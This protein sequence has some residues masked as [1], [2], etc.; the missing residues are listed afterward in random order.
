MKR[1]GNARKAA[2][3]AAV[4]LLAA[5]LALA[6]S[7]CG[8]DVSRRAAGT[9]GGA[10]SQA[11]PAGS[12]PY[13]AAGIED[14]EAFRRMFE[15][16]QDAVARGDQEKAAEYALYP[17]RVNVGK[18]AVA[19]KDREAFVKQYDRIFTD[20]VRKALAEQDA[21]KLFVNGEGVM[22]GSGAVWFGAT[23]DTPQRYG[24]ITVNVGEQPR[25]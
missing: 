3:S 13:A 21:D 16:V 1:N 24:I 19:V 11:A 15:A 20:K 18:V 17:I 2:R 25:F 22:A 8:N 9:A 10:P 6:A 4:V 12:N 23:S 14:P 7:A 5:G